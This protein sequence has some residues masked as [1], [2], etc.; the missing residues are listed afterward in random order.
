MKSVKGTATEKNLLASF[1]GESQ[2]RSRYTM[3]S[4][5]A[6]KEGYEQIAAIFMET[7]E[8]ELEHAKRFFRFLEGGVAEICATFPAGKEG[9]TAE[10]LEAAAHGENEEHTALY[11]DAAATAEKEGF[12][13]IAA[14]FRSVAKV[15][16]HHEERYLLLLEKVRE[17]SV[18]KKNETVK[19]KCR[20]CGYIHEGAEAPDK[21]PACIHPK[22]YFEILSE[23]Y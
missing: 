1:A 16:K 7:A 10:N 8:N 11:P 12:K 17:G 22:S 9:N 13:E 3:F 5:I 4:K 6:K 14:L 2:A 19:W 18:F 15:E 20:N 23:K 21:C